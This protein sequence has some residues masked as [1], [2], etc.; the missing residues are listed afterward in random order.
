MT[1][2]RRILSGRTQPKPQK[3]TKHTRASTS[4]MS[5]R[6]SR[7]QTAPDLRL[8]VIR[9][10]CNTLKILAGQ[11]QF[12]VGILVF[13]L[14]QSAC[15]L[16]EACPAGAERLGGICSPGNEDSDQIDE[17]SQHML[18]HLRAPRCSTK[19]SSS[20]RGYSLRPAS[21]APPPPQASALPLSR[22]QEISASPPCTPS[23]SSI[24]RMCGNG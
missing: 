22:S 23:T 1:T 20:P 13:N 6:A 19:Y 24:L 15:I 8:T 2:E 7:A 12:H 10:T 5:W 3:S 4:S 11:T 16:G 18:Q 21:L 14:P 9:I 17:V